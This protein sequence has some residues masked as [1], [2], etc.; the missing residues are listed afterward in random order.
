MSYYID[1]KQSFLNQ[2]NQ[3]QDKLSQQ[4]KSKTT[5]T[6]QRVEELERACDQEK[7]KIDEDVSAPA[8][9]RS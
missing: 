7:R 9:T 3:A 4:V 2:F 1:N 6:N 5:L 8:V